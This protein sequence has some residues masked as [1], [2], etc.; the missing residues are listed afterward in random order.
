MLKAYI[1]II[2]FKCF[3]CVIWTLQVFHLDVANVDRNVAC[4]LEI[5]YKR[6]FSMFHDVPYVS[7]TMLRVSSLYVT[8]V[9]Q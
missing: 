5:C 8:Y 6:L 7:H 1:A 9:L 2:C 3:R 4:V